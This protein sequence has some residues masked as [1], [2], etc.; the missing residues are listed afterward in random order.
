[1]NDLKGRRVDV[2]AHVKESPRQD[3]L[4]SSERPTASLGGHVWVSQLSWITE[5]CSP[6]FCIEAFL[7][8]L[9]FFL[10]D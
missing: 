4:P 8:L 9:I 6:V 1:M 2:E 10:Y 3:H 5:S 7:Y